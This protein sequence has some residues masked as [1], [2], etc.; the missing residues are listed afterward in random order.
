MSRS[1]TQKGAS[2]QGFRVEISREH[3]VSRPTKTA[4]DQFLQEV[5]RECFLEDNIAIQPNDIPLTRL[6]SVQLG[7]DLV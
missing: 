6:E 5:F 2:D 3:P 7:I 1:Q 4:S